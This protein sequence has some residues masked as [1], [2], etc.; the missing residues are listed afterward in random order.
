MNYD[1]L[2]EVNQQDTSVFYRT[3]FEQVRDDLGEVVADAAR[4]EGTWKAGK[5]MK[6]DVERFLRLYMQAARLSK[7]TMVEAPN[8]I[9]VY[10]FG[11][12][13]P[14]RREQMAEYAAEFLA[15]ANAGQVP[16]V[17]LKPWTYTPP[18]PSTRGADKVINKLVIA[19]TVGLV[20]YGTILALPQIIMSFT[21]PRRA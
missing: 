4:N 17:I 21:K 5:Y 11:K 15:M 9:D 19:G 1:Y 8:T 20:A 7:K 18:K 16:E 3:A 10:I 14:G 12:W 13:G 6:A 2:G